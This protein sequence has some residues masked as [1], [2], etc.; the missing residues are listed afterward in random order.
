MKLAFEVN[1]WVRIVQKHAIR[2][3]RKYTYKAC[4]Y[5]E[6]GRPSLEKH[7]AL[8]IIVRLALEIEG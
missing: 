8:F 6:P 1:E 7:I 5:G 4:R 2:H 3:S